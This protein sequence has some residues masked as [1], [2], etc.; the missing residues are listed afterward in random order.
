MKKDIVI[1]GAYPS[2]EFSKEVLKDCISRLSDS[3]DVLLTTHYPGGLDIQELVDYYIFDT[4][5]DLIE[6]ESNSYL[7]FNTESFYFQVKIV[8][9]YS[10]SAYSCMMNAVR[11]IRHKYEHIYF[12][13]GDTLM[14]TGDVQKLLSLKQLAASREKKFVAF[15]EFPGMVDT[16]I[17][18]S[19]I[20]YFIDLIGVLNNKEEFVKYTTTLTHPYSPCILESFFCERIDNWAREDVLIVPQK[21]EIYFSNSVIDVINC[22]G[23]T[24]VKKRN[25][26]TY[27]LKEKHSN[28]ILFVYWNTNEDGTSMDIQIKIDDRQ[29]TLNTSTR[30]F[31]QEI[32]PTKDIIT[33]EIENTPYEYLVQDILEN[34]QSYFEFK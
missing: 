1:V 20:D 27:L 25:Y 34:H 7:W 12:V 9:N 29:F 18:F 21:P 16:R 11:L 33:L 23:G 6:S 8:K 17:F 32:F 13:N 24:P 22:F 31:F 4:F 26:Q 19:E 2:T 15:Q 10:Y 14:G 30:W 28:R 5:N 3:F